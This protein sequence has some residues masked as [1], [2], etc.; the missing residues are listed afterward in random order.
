MSLE[1]LEEDLQSP[2]VH[3]AIE[4]AHNKQTLQQINTHRESTEKQE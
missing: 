4:L 1:E 3:I 2:L